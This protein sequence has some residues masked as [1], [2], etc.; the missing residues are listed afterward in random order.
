MPRCLDG[1][2]ARRMG[3]NDSG[4]CCGIAEVGLVQNHEVCGQLAPYRLTDIVVDDLDGDRFDV[5]QHGEQ[6]EPVG[7]PMAVRR[8]AG[9]VGTPLA[10]MTTRSGRGSSSARS[11]SAVARP[12]TS[13]QQ[14][15]PFGKVIVAPSP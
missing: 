10:S 7:A 4:C 1:G 15:H 12:S 8:N 11:S 9:E 13:E 5:G 3:L 2:H 14:M 6:V